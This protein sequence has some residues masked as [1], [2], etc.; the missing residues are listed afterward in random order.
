[1]M[2]NEP[3]WP[4]ATGARERFEA[5]FAFERSYHPDMLA[6]HVIDECRA[7]WLASVDDPSKSQIGGNG[8]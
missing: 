4:T 2:P 1:M 3:K 5:G 8:K 6:R 7:A